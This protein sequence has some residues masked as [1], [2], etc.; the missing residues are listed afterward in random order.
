MKTTDW[1][2]LAASIIFVGW[3]LSEWL[4]NKLRKR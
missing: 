3:L 1:L 4:Y 2:L